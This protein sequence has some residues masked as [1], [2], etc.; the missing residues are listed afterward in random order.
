MVSQK[1]LFVFCAAVLI[2][3]ALIS[4]ICAF[5]DVMLNLPLVIKDGTRTENLSELV[6]SCETKTYSILRGIWDFVIC[7]ISAVLLLVISFIFN[8]GKFRLFSILLS[9][10]SFWG[11]SRLFG[12]PIRFTISITLKILYKIICSVIKPFCLLVR[13]VYDLNVKLISRIK[14]SVDKRRIRKYTKKMLFGQSDRNTT[15][16]LTEKIKE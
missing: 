9:G 6:N 5:R 12:K 3:G 7:V 10:L 13:Y 16:M 11:F 1:D 2:H 15:G 8:D 14:K 4:V